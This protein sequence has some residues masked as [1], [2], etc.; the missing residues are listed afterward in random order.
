MPFR[1]AFANS[2]N[3]AMISQR[4]AVSQQALHDAA[5]DLGLGVEADL[6]APAFFGSVRRPPRGPSTRRRSSARARSRRPRSGWRLSPRAWRTVRG[7]RPSWSV[8]R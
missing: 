6:G 1:T 4:E 3:T 7:S 5:A 8:P 2:C